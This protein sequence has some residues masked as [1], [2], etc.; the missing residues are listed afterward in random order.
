MPV[1][2]V[3]NEPVIASGSVLGQMVVGAGAVIVL[4]RMGLLLLTVTWFVAVKPQASVTVRVYVVL[5]TMVVFTVTLDVL[6]IGAQ[7][8]SVVGLQS[9]L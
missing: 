2:P 9:K 6:Q 8:R 5:L 4:L 1:P 3:G 7:L